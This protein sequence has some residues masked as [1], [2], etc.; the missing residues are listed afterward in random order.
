MV[1]RPGTSA[2]DAIGMQDFTTDDAYFERGI[3]RRHGFLTEDYVDSADWIVKL[4]PNLCGWA[5]CSSR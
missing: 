1:R 3:N 2:Y 4:P 5:S